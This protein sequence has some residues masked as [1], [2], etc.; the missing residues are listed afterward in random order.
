[1]HPF[2][3]WIA[4][5]LEFSGIVHGNANDDDFGFNLQLSGYRNIKGQ[6]GSF[7]LGEKII[8]WTIEQY[9]TQYGKTFNFTSSSI[10][11]TGVWSF[12]FDARSVRC[13]KN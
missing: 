7:D 6:T 2:K 9:T 12:K 8:Y 4:L 10:S 13:L 3:T 5:S 1:M 11:T